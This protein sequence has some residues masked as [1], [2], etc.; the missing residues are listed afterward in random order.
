[1]YVKYRL[2]EAGHEPY[3][4]A[5]TMRPIKLVVHDDEP[6]FD[7]YVERPGRTCPV[8]IAFADVDPT[9][10]AAAVVRAAGSRSSSGW[11]RTSAGSSST[12]SPRTSRSARSATG[13]R[14]RQRSVISAGVVRRGSR[15]SPRTSSKQAVSTWTALQSS[16]G[17][18]SR[19][20]AGAISRSGR[21][22]FSTCSIARPSRSKRHFTESSYAGATVDGSSVRR[23]RR[24]R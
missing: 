9:E 14:C 20:A 11:I 3:V 1:M 6:G 17:T 24:Q 21:E 2:L 5:P 13:R 23:Q 22:P 19:A 4:A 16:T 8:D 18:W 10:F 12:S 15:R 7:T